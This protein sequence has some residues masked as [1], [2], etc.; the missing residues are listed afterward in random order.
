M[1]R[2][3][4]ARCSVVYCPRSHAFFG[5]DRHPVRELLNMGVNV[6]LGTDSLASN[7]TLSVLDEMR[8]LFKS[9][10]DLKGEE[11]LRMATLNGAAAL[12]YGGVLGRLQRGYW[13]DMAVL[14]L[15]EGIGTRHLLSRI[16]EG[17]GE[18]IG[19]IIQG[20]IAWSCPDTQLSVAGPYESW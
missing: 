8:F 19:T 9:R 1:S 16:L 18:C 17:A 15:P 13:A 6:A 14:R 20:K 4:N 7:D 3:L 2:I 10:K 5:H 12:H 11:I